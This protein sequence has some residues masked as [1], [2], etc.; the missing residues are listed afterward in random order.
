MLATPINSLSNP[1][2][3]QRQHNLPSSIFC[4]QFRQEFDQVHRTPWE[5]LT[6]TIDANTAAKLMLGNKEI[7]N[8]IERVLLKFLK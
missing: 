1:H 3:N 5:L 7:L 4:F 8:V 6:V 2:Q